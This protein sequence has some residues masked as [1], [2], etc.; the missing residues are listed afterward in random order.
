[1]VASLYGVHEEEKVIWVLLEQTD[2]RLE[3]VSLEI[4]SKGRQ[5][6]DESDWS[7]TGLLIGHHVRS[8]AEEAF[9]YGV[10]ELWLVDHPLLEQF[11]VDAYTHVAYQALMQ[12]R[13]S[14]FL[15]G[16]TVNGRDL[17]GR[18]AVRLKTGLN[19]DCTDLRLNAKSGVLTSEVTGFG[20]GVLALLESPDHR[21]QMST[22]RPGVFFQGDAIGDRTGKVV[23]M[24]VE[25]EKSAI[26]TRI[27]E[28]VTG[29]GVDLTQAP[30]LVC[31]G[32]GIAGKFEILE[33]LASLLGGEIGATRPPV[34]EGHI[35]RERQVGQ[36]GVVCR[37]K[38]AFACGISGAFH[39]L[40][41]IQNAD[42]VVAINSDPKAPIF[43]HAD[44]G[45]VG[46]ALKVVPALI[47]AFQV[48]KEVSHA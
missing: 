10:D 30:I 43:E 48:S 35:E 46:D 13:P 40:V 12:G 6:A 1:M 17:A 15:C 19:A 22:V 32:R 39:F 45:I 11:T 27:V 8:L 38:V 5:L 21:P 4:L 42:L 7:L 2:G 44:Y 41:G 3:N 20:G 23:E 14:I 36:T 24:Q 47:K 28:R 37:P 33:E 29:E 25:L 16:A 34:D 18:L 26:R 31:G 9:T